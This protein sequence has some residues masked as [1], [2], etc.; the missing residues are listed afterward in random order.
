M[1]VKPILHEIL[2]R[3]G[4]TQKELSLKAN[5]QAP[6]ISRFDSQISHKDEHL[7]LIAKALDCKI[8]DLFEVTDG[9]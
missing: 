7:F 9:N 5:I 3:K 8:E 2:K 1:I 6:Y 4:M